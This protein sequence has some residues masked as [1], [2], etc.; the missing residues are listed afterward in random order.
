MNYYSD[1]SEWKWLFNN[2]VNWDQIIPLFYP[3]FPTEDGLTSK[4]ELLS[5]FEEIL[6]TTGA[7][8]GSAILERAP[9]LDK[10]GPGEVVDGRTI[11]NETLKKTYAEALEMDLFG[12][13][14][15]R[16]YGG[17]GIPQIVH[18]IISGQ[19]ARSCVGQATQLAFYTSIAEMINRFCTEEQK[20]KYIPQILQGKLSGSMNLTEPGCGS[21]LSALKTKATPQEDG[22]YLLNGTKI[23]IT[24]GGGG[25]AF[26]LAKVDGA[27]DTLEGISMFFVEQDHVNADGETVLN[28]RVAKN[29][30]K[31]GM[32]ASFTTEIVY[33]NT[34]AHLVGEEGQGFSYM[35]HLMNESRVGVGLQGVGGLEAIAQYAMEYATERKAFGKPIKDLPLMR[36]NLQDLETERDALRALMMDTFSRYEVYQHYD[37]KMRQVGELTAK[38]KEDYE[39]AKL[40]TRKRT[41]L[42]KYYASEAYTHLAVKG[43]QVLGGYGYMQEYPLERYLRD[44]FGPLLYEGTSQIQ[45]LMALK[46]LVKYAMKDPKGFFGSVIA[47][48]PSK[49]LLMKGD[50]CTKSYDSFHYKFK[51]NLVKLLFRSLKPETKALFDFKAWQD[52]R[53]ISQLMTHAETLCQALSYMETLRVLYSHTQICDSRIDL[54]ERYARLV[55]PRLEAI[56]VDW[57]EQYEV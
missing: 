57:Q 37:H 56:Y 33:E 18:F 22:T 41:P 53:G 32:H 45:S 47:K 9:I 4:E 51:K 46:D 24:N 13:S 10:S 8:A 30:E 48:H 11:P 29:E 23:F 2:A 31:M 54:Y 49:N 42:V 25:L 19:L 52:E 38:E 55:R 50:P 35:L 43:I 40:W 39:E 34:V 1:E 27:P 20:E 26:V 5:F 6:S 17:M 21:D 36:R 44:S 15:P 12:L 16:K 14:L 3:E 7:W 28:F